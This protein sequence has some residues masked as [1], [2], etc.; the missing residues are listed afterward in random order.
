MNCFICGGVAHHIQRMPWGG[1]AIC[2]GCLI[3]TPTLCSWRIDSHGGCISAFNFT[4]AN[5]NRRG[6][7]LELPAKTSLRVPRTG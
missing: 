1:S 5:V 2:N 7:E 6:V 3:K 4:L